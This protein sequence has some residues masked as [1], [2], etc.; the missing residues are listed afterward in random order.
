[1]LQRPRRNRASVALRSMLRETHLAPHHLVLPLFVQAGQNLESP[2]SSMPGQARLSID[3]LLEKAHEA[4][5]LGLRGVAL[6][7]P[8]E[9]ALK[10]PR[11]RESQNPDGLLQ[12]A[13]RDLNKQVPELCAST[14]VAPDPD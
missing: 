14:D 6:F 1:M 3:R 10:D 9:D 8:L 11:G 2:I 5:R 4:A 7:P 13:V 12:R